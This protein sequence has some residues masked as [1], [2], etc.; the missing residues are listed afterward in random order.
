MSSETNYRLSPSKLS[1]F[2][3]NPRSFWL[4]E[5][6]KITRPRGIFPSLPGG[7]DKTLKDRADLCRMEGRMPPELVALAK[8]GWR[9]HP[10]QKLVDNLRMWQRAPKWTDPETGCSMIFAIDDLLLNSDGR[11]AP[12]DWKTK[13]GLPDTGYA[14]KYYGL[15][16]DCYRLLLEEAAGLSCA[17]TAVLAFFSPADTG[18]A[19]EFSVHVRFEVAVLP[20]VTDA[21]IARRRFREAI[22]CL[23]GPLP[24]AG[25][26]ES[27]DKWALDYARAVI[28]D[29]NKRRAAA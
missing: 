26:T 2:R 18:Q 9:L 19:S 7:M 12:L 3:E 10:D 29:E 14:S 20:V 21:E 23:R 25:P 27:W 28:E 17:E 24:P 8:Q 13:A 1:E 22:E 6:R 5:N 4:S 16:M 15:Q 11:V